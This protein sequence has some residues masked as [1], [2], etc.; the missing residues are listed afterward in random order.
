MSKLEFKLPDIGEGVAEGEIVNWL[1]QEG[2]AVAENQEMVEVMTDKAT[3]TIGAPKAGKVAERRFKVG[4]TVPVG[5]ILIV[6]ELEGGAGAPA[7]APAPAKAAAPAP[8]KAAPAAPASTGPV[9]SAVGDIRENLPGMGAPVPAPRANDY[10]AE[11]PHAAPATRKLARELGVDLREVAP[12]G[13]S[14]RV[15][16]EDVERHA[17]GPRPAAAPAAAS[18]PAAAP[19]PPPKAAAAD[20]RVP[21][22][23]LR[24]RI[25]ENMARSKHTAAHFNYVEECDV[26]RLIE[27]RERSQPHAQKQGVKLTFLPFIVK[28]AVAALKLHP[29]LNAVVDEQAMELVVRKTYDIGIAMATE[30]GLMVPVLRGADHLSLIDISRE[31]ERLAVAARD[32]KS[33]REDLGGST[34]TVSSLGKLGGLMAPPIINYPE[35]GI[36]GIHAIKKKPVVRGNEIVVGDVMLLTFSFD[37]RI[38]DGDVGAIFAQEIVSYLENPDRLLVEMS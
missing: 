1:V 5:E 37:H 25:F 27:L 35:V 13:S 2:D 26:G 14:G 36:M 19:P 21:I 17:S 7:A 24:K 22:R 34:F 31:I 12:S 6:L 3:V 16:R 9:A 15:T 28:A 29:R 38:I 23:G 4:D 18:A 11:K 30:A 32:G 10:F 8:A 20:E 33:Q